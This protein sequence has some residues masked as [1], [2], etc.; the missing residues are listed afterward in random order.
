MPDQKAEL[1]NPDTIQSLLLK[2]KPQM[3]AALPRHITPDRM[4][5]IALTALRIN[6]KLFRCTKESFFGSIITAS[7]IGLEPNVLGRAFLVPYKDRKQD[8][9]ICQLIPGWRG[10]MDLVARAGK[11]AAWTGAVYDGDFFEWGL[12]DRPYVKH[13]E[14]RWTGEQKALMYTYSCGRQNG[15]D[16]PNI[17]VWP[18]EKIWAHRNKY[19]RVGDQHYSYRDPEMYARKIPLLQVVKYL[20]ASVE[21]AVA[22]TLDLMGSEGRQRL[23]IDMSLK[24]DIGDSDPKETEIEGLMEQFDWTEEQR[25]SFR[26][27]YE[28]RP[29]AALE[30]L[31]DLEQKQSQSQRQ[32]G[33]TDKPKTTSQKAAEK[34]AEQTEEP[35]SN[36][37]PDLGNGEGVRTAEVKQDKPKAELAKKEASWW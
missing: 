20:P 27:G 10:H 12:G 36:L 4:A 24:G 7:T 32:Q 25:K 29:D 31:K 14:G 16:W 13:V 15:I 37:R 5:R 33:K 21:M 34:A 18:I 1:L 30:Y 26:E 17:E 35:K 9:S 3:E 23:T 2:M 28:G 22:Q 11:A 6:P 19:N 8:V